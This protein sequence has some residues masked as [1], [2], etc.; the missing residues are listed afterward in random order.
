MKKH[1]IESREVPMDYGIPGAEAIID[2]AGQ[3]ILIAQRFGG[4]GTLRGGSCRWE[5]GI[6]VQLQDGDTFAFLEEG[7]WNE[8]TTL[9]QAVLA[10]HDNDRPVLDWTGDRIAKVARSA[11]L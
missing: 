8:D 4:M 10:G 7:E 5:H 9:M 3:R 11:G 2:M 1:N 6:A